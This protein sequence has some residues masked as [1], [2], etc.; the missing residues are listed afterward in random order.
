M[1]PHTAELLVPADPPTAEALLEDAGGFVVVRGVGVLA[2][3]ARSD[4]SKLP[5][6]KSLQSNWLKPLDSHKNNGGKRP[7]VSNCKPESRGWRPE[8]GAW[9][10]LLNI[11]ITKSHACTFAGHGRVYS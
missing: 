6:S 4:A 3:G 10:N 5:K 8:G 7:I 1:H 2:A 9:R 11:V